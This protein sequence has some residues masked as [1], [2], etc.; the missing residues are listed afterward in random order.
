MD[1]RRRFLSACHRWNSEFW[2]TRDNREIL[3]EPDN[4]RTAGHCDEATM[5]PGGEWRTWRTPA[6]GPV[7][8][9]YLK[10]AD[11]WHRALRASVHVTREGQSVYMTVCG[12][13]TTDRRIVRSTRNSK[14]PAKRC[15]KCDLGTN[16]QAPA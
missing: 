14:R 5:G 10:T 16:E 12:F 3:E 2:V 11:V 13:W 7:R 8:R 9:M 15:E 1:E 6:E 4:G